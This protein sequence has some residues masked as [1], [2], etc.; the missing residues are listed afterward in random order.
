[1]MSA[2]P[3]NLDCLAGGR[4]VLHGNVDATALPDM[5]RTF[6]AAVALNVGMSA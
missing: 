1:M 5:G 6:A 4:D 2:T 3:F